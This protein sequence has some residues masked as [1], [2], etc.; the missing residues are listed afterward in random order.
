[1]KRLLDITNNFFGLVIALNIFHQ[2]LSSTGY[3][4]LSIPTIKILYWISIFIFAAEF[5]LRIGTEKKITFL[6]RETET[7]RIVCIMFW[8]SLRLNDAMFEGGA[9]VRSF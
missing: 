2:I 1:M 9:A 5:I 8:Q 3:L 7:F 6:L 4:A